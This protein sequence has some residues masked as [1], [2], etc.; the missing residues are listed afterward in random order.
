MTSHSTPDLN[1]IE[2]Y[3]GRWPDP[4]VPPDEPTWL[5]F[6]VD[7]VADVVLRTVDVFADGRIERNSIALEERKG[8]R[9][10][11]LVGGPFMETVRGVPLDQITAL[12]FEDL[13][14]Q[15]TD[16]PFWFP[17]GFPKTVQF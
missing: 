6:E 8:D 15:G 2:C 11:S 5:Y 16:T 3:A 12:E 7:T 17:D 4:E 10:V 13:W 1:S 9:C 14:R